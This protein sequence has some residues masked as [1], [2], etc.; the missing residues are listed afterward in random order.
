MPESI[1]YN[2]DLLEEFRLAAARSAS[3]LGAV[4]D[5]ADALDTDAAVFGV[6]AA[7]GSLA[8]AVNEAAG[9]MSRQLLQGE[10]LL[11]SVGRAVDSVMAAIEE[12]DRAG[13]QN[14]SG[15][16]SHTGGGK[17]PSGGHS[18]SGSGGGVAPTSAD[19]ARGTAPAVE[20]GSGVTLH[21]PDGLGTVRAPNEKAAAAVR[22]ALSQLGTPYVWGGETP[23][24]GFDCSGLTQ[25]AYGREGVALPHDAAAQNIGERVAE[26]NLAPGDLVVWDGHVAM[27]VGAGR[28]IEA[29]HTGADVHLTPLRTSN[30]GDRFEGFFRPTAR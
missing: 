29:P 27:Y 17:G 16:L 22:L 23:G 14:F 2:L 19:P 20:P 12:A 21:L 8:S 4:G 30:A 25:W 11:R 3:R 18:S 26:S 9:R 10:H 28:M 5:D 1:K 6:G 7:A 15:G 13:R 24:K